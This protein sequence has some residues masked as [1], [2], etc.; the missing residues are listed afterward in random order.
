MNELS[1]ELS[2]DHALAAIAAGRIAA[3]EPI[4]TIETEALEALADWISF[5]L[6]DRDDFYQRVLRM[7]QAELTLNRN[8]QEN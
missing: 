8:E 6:Q 2:R 1:N 7:N 3:A 4:R 5:E